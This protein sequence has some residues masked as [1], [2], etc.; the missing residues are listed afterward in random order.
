MFKMRNVTDL[1]NHIAYVAA[2]A[3]D[4]F[5]IEDFLPADQ[6]MNLDIAFSQ[7]RDGV[8]VAY[9]DF[10]PERM[11]QLYSLL[12]RALAAYLS[13]DRFKG[14]RILK[15]FERDIFVDR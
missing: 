15:E 5:P 6:Q 14:V 13:G 1:Y 7:L 9:S 8:A 4:G 3:P 10:H 2:C 11:A 12:D